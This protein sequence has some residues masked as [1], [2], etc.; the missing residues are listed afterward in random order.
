MKYKIL[1][2]PSGIDRK[3]WSAFVLAHPDGNIFQTPEFFSFIGEISNYTPATIAAIAEDGSI[4]GMITGVLQK[5]KNFLKSLFSARLI[6]WG[7][8]VVLNNN[9]E[10]VDLMIGTLAKTYSG[11][12]IYIEFRNLF[13]LDW[14][15]ESFRKYGFH[16]AEHLNFIVK[17]E[18]REST[19]KSLSSGKSRQIKKSQKNGA[20]IL[21]DPSIEQVRIFYTILKNLYQTK[22]KKPLPEWEFFERFYH[23]PELGRYLL[24]ESNGAIVG[25]IMCPVYK[26]ETIYE[27]YIAGED[28]QHEGIYPSILATWAPIDFALNN[29]LRYFDFM[30]A[31][32][33]AADYG[34]REFKAGFGGELKMYGRFNRINN[35]LLFFIGKTGLSILKRIK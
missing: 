20:K 34:V 8:P 24:I 35:R 1:T 4:A 33:P 29:G 16:Y 26:N 32:K 31:G 14:A 27:W 11:K 3:M 30:G 10:V 13:S 25:G 23:H 9:T 15:V 7:G 22:V 19:L 21:H 17:T 6:I 2:D 18:T 12:C 28:G 5:E